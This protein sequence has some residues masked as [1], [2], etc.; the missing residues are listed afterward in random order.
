MSD[1]RERRHVQTK[2]EIVNAALALF[3]AVGY[4]NATM[5]QIAQAAGVSRRTVYRRFP[6]K[7]AVLIEVRYAWFE[8]WDRALGQLDHTLNTADTIEAGCLAVAAHIDANATGVRVSYAA[9]AEA[10]NLHAASVATPE[11]RHRLENV[12]TSERPGGPVD[13]ITAR[14]YLGAIDAMMASWAET[15]G[16]SSVLAAIQP[17]LARVRPI[18]Q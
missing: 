11:W 16:T 14:A 1:L 6:T 2:T 7:E 5:D 17:V 9:L 12:L 18:T 10:P 4:S 3:D 15:G 13:E 8:A